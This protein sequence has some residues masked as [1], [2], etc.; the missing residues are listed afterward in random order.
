[1]RK[2]SKEKEELKIVSDQYGRP[3]STNDLTAFIFTLI[4]Q[5]PE[6]GVYHF[7]NDGVCNWYEF[8]V[9]SLK[10]VSFEGKVTECSSNDFVQ[11]A[12][13]PQNSILSLRK[14]KEHVRYEIPNWKTAL[15]RDFK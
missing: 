11:K 15:K 13:R 14:T 6:S 8:A 1:M 5:V 9:E 12:K 10:D 3:T 4:D 2:L 7:S